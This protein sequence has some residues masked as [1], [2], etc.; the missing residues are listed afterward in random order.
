[1][2]VLV[3]T[4]WVV[5]VVGVGCYVCS[6]FDWFGCSSRGVGCLFILA[7]TGLV[8]AVVGWVVLV[9]FGMVSSVLLMIVLFF[10]QVCKDTHFPRYFRHAFPLRVDGCVDTDLTSTHW[11]SYSYPCVFVPART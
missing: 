7:L 11:P 8:V 10:C 5:A 9:V 2:F 1:M 6:G 3:L 4:D